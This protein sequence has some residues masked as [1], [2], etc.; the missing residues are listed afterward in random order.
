MYYKFDRFYFFCDYGLFLFCCLII[1]VKAIFLRKKKADFSNDQFG[2][3][4]NQT[5]INYIGC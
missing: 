5:I 1:A 2:L 4:L 3:N